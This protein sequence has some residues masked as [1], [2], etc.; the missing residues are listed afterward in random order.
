MLKYASFKAYLRLRDLGLT[1]GE[2]RPSSS[3]PGLLSLLLKWVW[4]EWPSSVAPCGK[5]WSFSCDEHWDWTNK[6]IQTSYL[7]ILY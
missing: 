1:M 4:D 2:W 7:N 6:S 5:V 3:R